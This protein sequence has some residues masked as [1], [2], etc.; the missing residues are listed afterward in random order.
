MKSETEDID[1]LARAIMAEA[2]DEATQLLT[3]AKAKAEVIR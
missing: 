3:E 2:N 1:L